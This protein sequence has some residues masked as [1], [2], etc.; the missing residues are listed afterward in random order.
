MATNLQKLAMSRNVEA[1]P[2][3]EPLD[4]ATLEMVL[5]SLGVSPDEVAAA[6]A[7]DAAAASA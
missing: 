1:F 2:F 4:P 6:V 3:G 7:G 5:L